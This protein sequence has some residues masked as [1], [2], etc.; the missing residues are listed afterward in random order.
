MTAILVAATTAT[1]IPS[2]ST[3]IATTMPLSQPCSSC[4][5]TTFAFPTGN[6]DEPEVGPAVLTKQQLADA[7]EK[8]GLFEIVSLTAGRFDP[9]EAYR[10]LPRLPLCWELVARRL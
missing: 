6:A 5:V 1:T 7:F 8:S 2:A 4:T 10:T 9:T 3:T